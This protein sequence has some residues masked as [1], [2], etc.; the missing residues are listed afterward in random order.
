MKRSKKEVTPTKM[1]WNNIPWDIKH[2]LFRELA[3]LPLI[4]EYWKSYDWYYAWR[5]GVRRKLDCWSLLLVSRSWNQDLRQALLEKNPAERV[6]YW[7][8]ESLALEAIQRVTKKHGMVPRREEQT[9]LLRNGSFDLD[10]QAVVT[11]SMVNTLFLAATMRAHFAC[12]RLLLEYGAD[13][14]ITPSDWVDNL[15]SVAILARSI[16]AVK[17]LIDAGADI[18]HASVLSEYLQEYANTPLGFAI[19]EEH[20]PSIELLLARGANPNIVIYDGNFGDLVDDPWEFAT[21][22]E[23][24]G[25]PRLLE[26]FLRHGMFPDRAQYAEGRHPVILALKAFNV[27]CAAILIR[28]GAVPEDYEEYLQSDTNSRFL[29]AAEEAKKL[30]TK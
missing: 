1:S 8:G 30:V 11:A 19:L 2:L 21:R 4:P 3:E 22:H 26:V 14:S 24:R 18:N 5:R 28:A 7:M 25:R 9:T 6:V 10:L 13:H 29:W 27:E 20:V 12:M 23:D 17:L 16:D 15:V